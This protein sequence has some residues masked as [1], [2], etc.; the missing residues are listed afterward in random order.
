M[1]HRAGIQKRKKRL[2]NIPKT[3]E[4][5]RTKTKTDLSKN[6]RYSYKIKIWK[7]INR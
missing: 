5:I 2:R 6:I 7:K 1:A 4:G 3:K